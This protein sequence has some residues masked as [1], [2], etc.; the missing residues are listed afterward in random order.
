MLDIVIVNHN[1]TDD[2]MLCLRSIYDSL[3]DISTRVFI[4]DNASDDDVDRLRSRFPQTMVSKNRKNIGFARAV[5]KGLTQSAAPYVVLINPDTLVREGCFEAILE[6]M[7]KNTDIGIVGPRILDTDGTTQGSARAFPSPFTGLFGRNTLLTKWFPN[8]PMTRSNIFT[9]RGDE[10]TPMDVDWV[11]GA[12]MVVRR[13]AINDVGFMDTRF[14]LYWEDADWCRRMWQKGWKVVYHPVPTV[15]HSIGTSS[16]KKP[17]RSLIEFHKS[18]YRLFDKYN[19]TSLK[20]L[21]PLV[22]AAL[23]LRLVMSIL[24][25]KVGRALERVRCGKNIRE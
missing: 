10:K 25:N 6:H 8:N 5:N 1:S 18:C 21:N 7:E 22:A 24:L 14:F 17:A 3:G 23:A 20:F 15:V 16:S 11:S 4:Q 9:T 12:C 2:L 13:K 19:R